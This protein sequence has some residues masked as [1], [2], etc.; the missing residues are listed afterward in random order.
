LDF[1][2]AISSSRSSHSR[3]FRAV[4]APASARSRHAR[5]SH[6]QL[7]EAPRLLRL[8][9]SFR[10]A[11]DTRRMIRVKRLS[12]LQEAISVFKVS[13]AISVTLTAL[14]IASKCGSFI[15]FANNPGGVS[16]FTHY[17]PQVPF[18]CI[19]TT[20]INNALRLFTSEQSTASNLVSGGQQRLGDREAER[21]CGLEVEAP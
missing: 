6:V 11:G 3:S 18:G 21:L 2:R 14:R 10:E 8:I 5:A 15:A 17:P 4:A 9:A 12:T 20:W 13:Y 7:L 19:V 1:S 16:K